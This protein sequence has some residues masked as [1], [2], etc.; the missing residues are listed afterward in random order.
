MAVR[1]D[2]ARQH[3]AALE[4]EHPVPA[5]R[6]FISLAATHGDDSAAALGDRLGA[7]A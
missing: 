1:I 3:R 6:S 7:H 2:E 4:V 5:P